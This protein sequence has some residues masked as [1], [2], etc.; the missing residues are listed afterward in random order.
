MASPIQI[1][2]NPEHYE[3][4]RETAGGGPKKDF[5]A[6]R[7]RE[8][9]AHKA[10]LVEQLRAIAKGL[11]ANP[12]SD[13]GYVKVILRRSGWAK[14]HRPFRTLF[15]SDRTPVVG[16]ADLGVVLVEAQPDALL[17]IAG[18]VDR[19][20]NPTTFREYQGKR[21]PYPSIRRSEV[22][23]IEQ[24]ELYGEGDRRDFSLEEAADWLSNPITGGCYEVE[25]FEAPPAP[26]NWDALDQGRLRLFQSFL[27]G[28][29]AV[30]EGLTV[31]RLSTRGRAQPL[32]SVRVTRGSGAPMLR[33][34]PPARPARS[35][36]TAPFD[37]SRN[38]HR[39]LLAFLDG[40]PLVRRVSLPG[41]VVRT[42]AQQGR[43][44]PN[45][46]SV[47]IRDTSRTH[48][49]I[50][51]VDGGLGAALSD[52][53]IDRWDLLAD[54]HKDP[55]HG[56]F[57]G[58]LAVAGGSLNGTQ[59]CPEP[60]GA[61]LVDLAIFPS[62]GSGAIA[63][64][65]PEGL[66]QFFDE[67]ETAIGD[68]RSRRGVRIF[69]MSLNVLQPAALDRYGPHAARLDS[70]SDDHDAIVF[71]SAGNLPPGELRPEWPADAT[72]ALA[73]IAASID[74]R[75]LSP[76]ESA[77]NVAVAAVNPPDHPNSVPFAP[78]RY[79]RRGPG[80]RAGVKPDL[81]HVGG[82]GSPKPPLEHA[83]FSLTPDGAITSG[84]GTSYATPLV[85]KTAAAL[86]HAIE[87]SVSRETLVGL[88]IHHARIPA[89]LEAPALAPV[90]R[91]LVGF[92]V[93]PSAGRILETDDHEITLVFASRV[94]RDQQVAFR[95]SW[96][97]SLVG[98]G[99]RCRGAARLTLVSTPPLDPRFGSEF[100]RINL[101][102]GLQQQQS[103]GS[104]KGRL[105]PLYL[106][107]RGDSPAVEA[108]LIRH[109]LK[110][111]P[112]KVFARQMPRGVGPSSNWRLAV[113]YLTRAG[114]EMPDDGVPFTAILT[115]SDPERK[116]PVFNELRQSL[117]ALGVQIADIRTAARITPRV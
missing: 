84:C 43:V 56:S 55:A 25:L 1:V 36:E 61:E 64:Y 29:T 71:V 65:Y 106:P 47:P 39:R 2:L 33:L 18:D 63:S 88:L 8:F 16:G 113:N 83:L 77:R 54:E 48:P 17:Q 89:P 22:G 59:C 21:V 51:I 32:L 23:A 35:R 85:A 62:E 20:E 11:A 66:P 45:A 44:R 80:L 27:A 97:A 4:S 9:R 74:D 102:A 116:Q 26:G 24:I 67:L 117:L 37:P 31:Q 81:A 93:P 42:S 70:I 100:V 90:A 7:D 105:E 28:L 10:H 12:H 3:E 73:T 13:L 53:V 82:S 104:W 107:G 108:E 109:A 38:R 15:T 52:W 68:V 34:N 76:A 103:D 57:I 19:A 99:G 92:G 41:V 96:P 110:W 78:G 46:A 98:S 86:D 95:F 79:S 14:S 111:S 50:G 94:R 49:R 91:Q 112:V 87:G 114:E 101:E 40:H 72:Q 60:D 115:I 69:N 6:N 75:L 5:F 58:G 30:G